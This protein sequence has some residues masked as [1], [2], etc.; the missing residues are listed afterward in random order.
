VIL[1]KQSM[2]SM[3]PRVSFDDEDGFVEKKC[4][5]VIDEALFSMDL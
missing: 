3:T 5:V 2:F 4:V 1:E